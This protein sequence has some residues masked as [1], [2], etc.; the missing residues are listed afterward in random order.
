MDLT[1]GGREICQSGGVMKPTTLICFAGWLAVGGLSAQTPV[2]ERDPFA[3]PGAPAPTAPATNQTAFSIVHEEFSLDLATAADLRR[4]NLGDAALYEVML[5]MVGKGTAKQESMTIV[6]ALPGQKAVGESF[7]ELMYPTEWEPAELPNTVGVSI[8]PP[9]PPANPD[10]SQP[11][12]PAVI[13]DVNALDQAPQVSDLSTLATPATGTTFRTRNSGRTVEV[14][15]TVLPS[16][17]ISLRLACEHVVLAGN[18]T[19]GQGASELTM[20]DF[21]S[22]L[23]TTALIVSPGRPAMAGTVNRPPNSKV[24]ADAA[25]RIW[26]VFVTA[27]VVKP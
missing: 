2:A 3:D 19:F 10:G 9:R 6:R 11:S 27:D 16:G 24:D 22:Q 14:E 1:Q 5:E 21:E 18:S 4:K 13:P 23:L 12:A 8:V 26:F 20:P 7:S 15:P 25:G 17:E